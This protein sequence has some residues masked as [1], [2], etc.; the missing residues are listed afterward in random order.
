[1]NNYIC[2][3]A[4]HIEEPKEIPQKATEWVVQKTILFA[5]FLNWRVAEEVHNKVIH[6]NAWQQLN[7][8]VSQMFSKEIMEWKNSALSNVERTSLAIKMSI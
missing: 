2:R 6:V 1:M 8:V 4:E 5:Q 3:S 7:L